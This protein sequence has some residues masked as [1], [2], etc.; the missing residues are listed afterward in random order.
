MKDL[1]YIYFFKKKIYS[2]NALFFLDCDRSG[3]EGRGG[4]KKVRN[5]NVLFFYLSN[6]YV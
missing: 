4:G 5:V 2:I 3:K 6:V 1:L